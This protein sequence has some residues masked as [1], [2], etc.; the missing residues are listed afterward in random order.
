[1]EKVKLVIEVEIEKD[2]LWDMGTLPGVSRQA[3]ERQ[4]IP[5]RNYHHRL[6][7][8]MLKLKAQGVD[9][10]SVLDTLRH[11]ARQRDCMDAA[12]RNW[13]AIMDAL[14]TGLYDAE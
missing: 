5:E 14:Q 9:N 11:N 3:V 8:M 10:E 13:R 6:A 4:L 12:M 1:M 7:K 2:G